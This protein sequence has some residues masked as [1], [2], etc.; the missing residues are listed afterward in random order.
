[1]KFFSTKQEMV[2]TR[3]REG[4]EETTTRACNEKCEELECMKTD[5]IKR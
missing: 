4:I 2:R 3:D 5:K 1:M